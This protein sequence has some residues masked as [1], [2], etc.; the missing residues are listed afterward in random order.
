MGFDAWKDNG[1][2][3]DRS[4]FKKPDSDVGVRV[5]DLE[6]RGVRRMRGDWLSGWSGLTGVRSIG[7]GGR[8]IRKRGGLVL[9]G[10]VVPY[11]WRSDVIETWRGG[12]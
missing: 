1:A 9:S 12:W 4:G 3:L 2:A 6:R 10:R 11:G 8:S 5:I 7:R